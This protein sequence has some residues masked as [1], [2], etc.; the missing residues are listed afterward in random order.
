MDPADM[1]KVGLLWIGEAFY[2]TARHFMAEAK[3][4]GISRRI[5]A[6][7]RNFVAGQTWVLLA[8]PRHLTC[9]A[10]GGAGRIA[11]HETLDYAK[12]APCEGKG[13]TPAVFY[14]WKPEAVEKILPESQR[15][16]KEAQ[17]LLKRGIRPVYVPDTD[18][19]HAAPVYDDE[20]S[21]E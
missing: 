6:V 3:M 18:K 1:G 7:P 11:D 17:D 8:H 9:A 13:A 12:C 2:K 21:E 14:A 4:L 10:C 15:D 16:S 20:E 19:D 5:H